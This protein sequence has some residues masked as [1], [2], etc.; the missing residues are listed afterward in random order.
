[1]HAIERAAFQ[2]PWSAA[3]LTACLSAD[4]VFLVA[5]RAGAIVGYAIAQVAADEAEIVNVAVAPT[6]RGR[7]IGRALVRSAVAAAASCGAR[8]VYLEVRESNAVA[9]RLYEAEG[10]AVAGRRRGYYRTPTE[11]AILLRAAIVADEPDA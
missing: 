10:F 5:E 11:D 9:R 2:D 4:D 6:A 7:G 3:Q 1:M 8:A